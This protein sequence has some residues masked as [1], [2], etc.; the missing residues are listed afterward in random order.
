MSEIFY[1]I[2]DWLS[3]YKKRHAT[4]MSRHGINGMIDWK[5]QE[6][7]EPAPAA[8]ELGNTL[9]NAFK[10]L[11]KRLLTRF[12][13]RDDRSYEIEKCFR[14]TYYRLVKNRVYDEVVLYETFSRF[15]SLI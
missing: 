13:N 9:H 6:L 4:M 1:N 10:G 7:T 14:D 3:T 5:H 2:T 8:Y 11:E 12:P 15:T